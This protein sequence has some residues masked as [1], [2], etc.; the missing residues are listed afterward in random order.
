MCKLTSQNCSVPEAS[1]ASGDCVAHLDLDVSLLQLPVAHTLHH[2][3]DDVLFVIIAGLRCTMGV[4]APLLAVSKVLGGK[5]VGADR[6]SISHGFAADLCPLSLLFAP[7]SL[8]VLSR[9]REKRSTS[10]SS[11][12]KQKWSRSFRADEKP[13]SDP[14]SMK[15]GS[16]GKARL[17]GCTGFEN[18][19]FLVSR[20]L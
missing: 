4:T 5:T 13:L 8:E 12:L 18:S 2:L 16:V 10:D 1:T 7:I 17:K 3:S 20:R 19:R 14:K 9:D 6:L 11:V 15:T